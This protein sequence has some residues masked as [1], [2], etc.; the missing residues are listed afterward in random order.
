MSE[1][2][3]GETVSADRT[4]FDQSSNEVKQ[5]ELDRQIKLGAMTAK[6]ASVS[7]SSEVAEIVWHALHSQA[8]LQSELAYSKVNRTKVA[9]SWRKI[10]R[11]A[12][13][14]VLINVFLQQLA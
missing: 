7:V 4:C 10:L 6:I 11:L 5:I 8:K 2:G 14:I 1:D 13:V 3:G 12:K 9:N